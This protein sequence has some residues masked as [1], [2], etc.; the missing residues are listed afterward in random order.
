MEGQQRVMW[1]AFKKTQL[2]LFKWCWTFLLLRA[3]FHFTLSRGTMTH[4][5]CAYFEN[6]LKGKK[7]H[8]KWFFSPLVMKC[9]Q[10]CSW[11]GCFEAGLDVR[12]SCTQPVQCGPRYESFPLLLCVRVSPLLCTREPNFPRR[13]LTVWSNREIW[14][15]TLTPHCG[16]RAAGHGGRKTNSVGC[17]KKQ[18]VCTFVTVWKVINPEEWW[19]TSGLVPTFSIIDIDAAWLIEFLGTINRC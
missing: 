9:P 8:L 11:R 6:S 17:R 10:L 12:V 4:R 1:H 15:K 18:L 2:I 7:G 3:S 16:Q 13:P 14:L 5:C 19:A